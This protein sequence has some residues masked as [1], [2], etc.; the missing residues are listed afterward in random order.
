MTR[1]PI[2]HAAN[3]QRFRRPVTPS[4]ARDDLWQAALALDL[5]P[6]TGATYQQLVALIWPVVAS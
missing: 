1:R 2:T 4:S 3:G 6:P 5:N